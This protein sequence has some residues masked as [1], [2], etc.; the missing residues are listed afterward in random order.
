MPA[1]EAPSEELPPIDISPLPIDD[2]RAVLPP[3]ISVRMLFAV[4]APFNKL[5]K[6]KPPDPLAAAEPDP[7]RKPSID[8]PMLIIHLRAVS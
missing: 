3:D 1:P 6:L 2:E 7:K 5:L 8:V 4:E